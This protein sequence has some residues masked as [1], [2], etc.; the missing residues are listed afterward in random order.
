MAGKPNIDTSARFWKSRIER[1]LIPYV[2]W[3]IFFI[4]LKLIIF[5]LTN[6]TEQISSILQ[7]PLGIIFFGGAS[8][9]LYFLP[10]LL[11]GSSLVFLAKYLK[12]KSLESKKLVLLSFISIIV[13]QLIVWS[14][15]SFYPG[16]N[17][18]FSSW[19]S[20]FQPNEI[21]YVVARLI[22]VEAAW[23]IR[24]LP[25][26]LVALTINK[27]TSKVY[28]KF[29]YKHQAIYC[30]LSF[31]LVNFWGQT[32]IPKS[33]KEIIVSYSLLYF[34][35]AISNYFKHNQ[36]IMNLGQCSFGI[37]LIHPVLK[38]TVEIIINQAVPFLTQN[39]SIASMLTY[40]V[41]T[42]IISWIAVSIM[43]RNKLIAKYMFGA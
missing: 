5:S 20:L 28:F 42:F 2:V 13:D 3:S 31:S 21:G 22:L 30:L 6:Q 24:C 11:T 29:D 34:A 12:E 37:Y 33:F 39:V 32:I 8:Y 40:S 10:L 41:S 4:L 14:D 25:Y 1:I 19:L 36:L 27:L 35:I 15:N 38:S 16:S 26:L 18:A 17:I 23:L 43:I 9:H 7:D